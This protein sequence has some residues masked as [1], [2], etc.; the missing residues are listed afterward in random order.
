MKFS[1][2]FGALVLTSL[3]AS[4]SARADLK[5]YYYQRYLRKQAQVSPLKGIFEFFTSDAPV[6]PSNS[7]TQELTYDQKVNPQDP[8]DTRTFKQRYYLNSAY[9]ADQNSPVFF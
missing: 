2:R 8:T 4:A 3:V 9:A 7:D 1:V 6:A 5:D